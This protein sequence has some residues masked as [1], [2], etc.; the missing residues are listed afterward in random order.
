MK[1]FFKNINNEIG[2]LEV[3]KKS[4][5]S[6]GFIIGGICGILAIFFY[7]EDFLL[8]ARIAGVCSAVLISLGVIAPYTLRSVYLWWMRLG[9][10]LG[11]IVSPLILGTLYYFFFTPIAFFARLFGASTMRK[12]ESK[13]SYWIQRKDIWKKEDA[14]KLY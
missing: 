3:T 11:A 8:G 7:R 5:V 6:F 12:K 1:N 14:E 13:K 2:K 4:L 9:F 10:L